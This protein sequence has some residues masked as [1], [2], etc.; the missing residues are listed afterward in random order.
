MG[1]GRAYGVCRCQ[2]EEREGAE[3]CVVAQALDMARVVCDD[4]YTLSV[5]RSRE[6]NQAMRLT[7][8]CAASLPH[9]P[10][11]L[12]VHIRASCPTW[13]SLCTPWSAGGTANQVEL[14]AL[15]VSCIPDI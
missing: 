11:G 4:G 6:T 14:R 12:A 15:K 10:L 2:G 5:R 3:R 13:P 8:C 7:R 1:R 9:A